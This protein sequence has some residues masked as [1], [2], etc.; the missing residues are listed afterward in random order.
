MAKFSLEELDEWADYAE[1]GT[2]AASLGL[3]GATLVAPNP[4]TGALALGTNIASAGIDLYQG[5]R[6]AVRGEWGNTA[7]NAGELILSLVGAKA[8]NNGNKL[9]KA[10]KA[11]AATNAPREYVT[12]TI[13]RGRGRRKINVTKENNDAMNSYLT[14][15]AA[16][17][18]IDLFNIGYAINGPKSNSL[19]YIAPQDNINVKQPIVKP[20]IVKNKKK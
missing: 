11:L 15:Y 19:K 12:K 1:T 2:A 9:M 8:I 20:I 3:T 14:G 17:N 4:V 16:T 6:S 5:I 7:K 10:D 13:G 18:G